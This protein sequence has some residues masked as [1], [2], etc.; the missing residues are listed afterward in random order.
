[1]DYRKVYFLDKKFFLLIF[2]N[3]LAANPYTVSV[4]TATTPSFN[5]ISEASVIV[6]I[7]NR[8]FYCKSFNNNLHLLIVVGSSSVEGFSFKTLFNV[9]IA[10]D[11]FPLSSYDNAKS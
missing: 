1:M 9:L 11:E 8:I 7:F 5:K 3:Q 10:N 2:Q 6:T 4:G